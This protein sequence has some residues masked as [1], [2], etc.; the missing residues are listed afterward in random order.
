MSEEQATL[1]NPTYKHVLTGFIM[2]DVKGKGARNKIAK[3]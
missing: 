3:H 2:Y 1:L